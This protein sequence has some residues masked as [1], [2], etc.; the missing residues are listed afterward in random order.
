MENTLERIALCVEVGKINAKTPYPPAMKGEDGADELT[1]KAL[2][3]GYSP[4][5]ILTKG[6]IVGMNRI[7]V[8]FKENKVFVPQVLMSAKAMSG[9]MQHLKKYFNDGSVKRKGKLIIG[10]VKGDLHDIGK[11]LVCMMVEGNG[12]E[13]IDLGVDVPEER[14]VDAVRENPDAFVGMS[15]LLTTTMVNMETINN[16]IK[17]E[18]PQVKT[19]IGGAPVSSDFARQIGV[20]YYT[21]EPQRLVE[22]LNQLT[23]N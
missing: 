21:E 16:A 15:A 12:Y 7:G 1:R 19:F 17:A 18:F 9:G 2:E 20:D 6:L 23:S 11:N 13:I 22:I 10:T 5:D 4:N 14:F 8:K 3:E